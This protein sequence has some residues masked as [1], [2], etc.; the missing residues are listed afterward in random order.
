MNTSAVIQRIKTHNIL[1]AGV[2]LGFRGL[3]FRDNYNSQWEGFDIDLAKAVA[4]AVL[5]NSK[6]INFIPLQSGNRFQALKDN[7]IDLGC[8]N[9]SITF[10][11][12][13]EYNVSFAHPMLFDGEVLMTHENNLINNVSEAR[14]TKKREIAA[15]RGS[16]TQENLERY[17]AE[18]GLNCNIMLFES[19]Q[20]AREAY[21]K[22]ICNI[23]CLDSYLLAGERIQLKAPEKHLFL[24]DRISLEAMSPAV[25]LHD[26]QWH[27]SV[28]WIMKALIEAENLG[29]TRNNVN[30]KY[31][32]STGYINKFLK[33]SEELCNNLGLQTEFTYKIIRELGNYGEIFERNLGKSSILNQERKD[34]K[35]WSKGG[36]LYSPLFI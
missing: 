8:F 32:I 11:R 16:T 22:G 9:S 26:P 24:K 33:P 15:M 35:P 19:P 6:K 36:M 31:N 5:G 34:N 3:S 28:S 10:Q 27:A 7:I 14:S 20:D 13:S 30:D 2:S 17:F 21:Q 12:E 4:I 23:Y 29:I 25:S 1:N 18:L